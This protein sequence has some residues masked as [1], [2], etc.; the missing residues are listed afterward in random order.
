MNKVSSIEIIDRRNL[1]D[2][3]KFRLI[4]TSNIENYFNQEN[5]E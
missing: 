2:P 1:T 5:M 4:E 3:T